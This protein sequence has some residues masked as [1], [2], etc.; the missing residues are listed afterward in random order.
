MVAEAETFNIN[1]LLFTEQ[2][3]KALFI[4]CYRSS[5]HWSINSNGWTWNQ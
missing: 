2:T 1:W 5:K 4:T 3:P